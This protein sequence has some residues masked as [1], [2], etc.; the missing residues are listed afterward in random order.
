LADDDG[1]MT[2]QAPAKVNLVLR[3]LA[4]RP[5]GYHDIETLMVPVSLADSLDIEVG[6]GRG[7]DL[8]CD[9]PS[10]PTGAQNLVWRAVEVFQEFT[11]LEFHTQILLRKSIPHGAGLG[12]GSSD[13]AAVLRVLNELHRTRLSDDQLEALAATLGSDTP[14]FIRPCPKFCRGRGEIMRDTTGVPPA[15]ILLLKPPF[16]VSTAWAYKS[17]RSGGTVNASRQFHGPIE[18][19]NDFEN[20]V[21]EKYL[22][23]PTIKS[24]LLEQSEVASAMM[25]GSG[26]TLFAILHG[27]AGSLAQRA[28]DRFGPSLWTAETTLCS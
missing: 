6:S 20:T 2:I 27:N 22:L 11:R 25:S 15:N 12:G 18:L 19:V 3:I 1:C 4:K 14:F 10:L 7:V 23:L 24:W 16:P 28:K 13:A 17:W 5:D 9:D 21:F 26:S 8:K